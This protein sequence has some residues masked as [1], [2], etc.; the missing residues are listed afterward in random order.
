MISRKLWINRDFDLFTFA[1]SGTHLYEGSTVQESPLCDTFSSCFPA[2]FPRMQHCVACWVQGTI[3]KSRRET[4]GW[5]KLTYSQCIKRLTRI[6][7]PPPTAVW[8]VC[9]QNINHLGPPECCPEHIIITS[10][11]L[12]SSDV[13]MYTWNRGTTGKTQKPKLNW[14]QR[15][16]KAVVR[17][18]LNLNSA[19]FELFFERS[20]RGGVALFSSFRKTG[21][22]RSIWMDK[23]KSLLH[24]IWSLLEIKLV[25]L[26]FLT[27]CFNSKFT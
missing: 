16:L 17:V 25:S 23:S 14:I 26:L 9:T 1:L 18:L 2:L 27:A 6:Y 19:L 20:E 8:D 4:G 24:V 22:F 11:G 3:V 7:I 5:G 21:G 15:M 10:A 13:Q 12:N